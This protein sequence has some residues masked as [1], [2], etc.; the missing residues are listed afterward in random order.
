MQWFQLLSFLSTRKHGAKVK[1]KVTRLPQFRVAL[2]SRCGRACFY[3]RPSGEAVGTAA[4]TELKP[5]DLLR[6]AR[7]VRAHGI[8]HI[9][10]TGG[11]PALYGPLEE[12]ITELRHN[13]GFDEVEVISRHPKFGPRAEALAKAGATQLNMSIDT[14]NP[15]L[16]RRIVGINDHEHVLRALDQCVATGVA[17]KVNIVVMAGVNE[18][19]IVDLV[20][21]LAARGVRCIKLLD[22]IVDLDRG[23]ESFAH[24]LEKL[25]KRSLEELYAPLERVA[26]HLRDLTT[27]F[28]LRSQGDLG[29]PMEVLKLAGGTEVVLK[30]SR[31]GAW[32]GSPCASCVFFPCHDA[33]MA[34]RLTADTRLQ[35]CLLRSDLV[36]PL[37]KIID[38][39]EALSREIDAALNNYSSAW[40]RPSNTTTL[41]EGK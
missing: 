40:F 1:P 27:S 38:D 16:H 5:S 30:D 2:N 24:R 3:C 25:E 14:L 37:A 26:K 7:C 41:R 10:L 19:E 34:L 28:E 18:H 36:T 32:Y 31:A 35:V 17:C 20:T 15:E 22:V 4:H 11:D 21:S 6:V 8:R 23:D 39:D 33:L 12:V 13:I 9:K 29:H